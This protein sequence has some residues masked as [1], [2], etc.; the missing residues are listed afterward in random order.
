MRVQSIEARVA[1]AAPSRDSP[2]LP[3][4]QKFPLFKRGAAETIGPAL[5]LSAI[6][7]SGIMG[8]RLAGGNT[9]I[10]LVWAGRMRENRFL[11]RVAHRRN[12]L[13]PVN[14]DDIHEI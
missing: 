11:P 14:E 10:A 4:V 12:E 1:K 9:A 6:V 5:L 3:P 13:Q 2:T 8:E 7:G